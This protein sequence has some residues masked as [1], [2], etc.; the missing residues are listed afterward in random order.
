[1]GSAKKA[2]MEHEENLNAAAAYLVRKNILEEC[3]NHGELSEGS[4]DLEGDFWAEATADWKRGENGPVPWA[5]DLKPRE[6][7]D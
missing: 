2:M 6:Y 7:T 4:R 5:A 1:M 3:P